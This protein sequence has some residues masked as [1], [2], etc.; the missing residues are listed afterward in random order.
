VVAATA[1]AASTS[2]AVVNLLPFMC[3]PFPYGFVD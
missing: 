1:A 2:R 3:P